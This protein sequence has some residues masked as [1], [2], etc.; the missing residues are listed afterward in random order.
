MKKIRF[1]ITGSGYMG[2]THAEAIKH[3]STTA[4][5][6]AIWGGTRAEGLAARCGAAYEP[7]L[8]GLMKRRDIDAIVV[9]TPHQCHVKEVMLALEG[10]KHVL[11]E[12]PMATKLED[13]DLMLAAAAKRG[14]ITAVAHN[15]RFRINLP[16]LRQLIQEGT[17]G[18][19]QSMHFSMIRQLVNAG[20]FGGN[21]TGWVN[22]P[23]TVGFVIDGLPHGVDAMRW[24]TGAEVIRVAG[25]S[26]TYTPGRPIEDTTVGIMEYSNGAICS[27]HTT[28]ASHGDFN[29][30][31]ARLMICGDRG[32]VNMDGFGDMHLTDREQGWRLVSTQPPV[33]AD[34]PESAY[35]IGRMLAF[36]N[37][38]QSFIDGIH[39][40]PSHVATGADGRAGLAACLAMLTSSQSGRV[41]DLR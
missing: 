34:D 38:I 14:L 28:I 11:I 40:K 17:L 10:G 9:T 21:K 36:Q 16:K 32:S 25:F 6:V 19:V 31:M 12:K 1:G 27:V 26:R 4:E 2:R 29:G 3:L 13:C 35:K 37:Q 33:M 8:E 18:K 41:I 20:N 7:T 30:E 23:E 5:L 22:Q 15:L 39:G 24:V